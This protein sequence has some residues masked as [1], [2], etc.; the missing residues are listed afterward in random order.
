MSPWIIIKPL[1]FQPTELDLSRRRGWGEKKNT[2]TQDF[3]LDRPGITYYC[4]YLVRVSSQN[5]SPPGFVG[6]DT[7]ELGDAETR[8][9][10]KQ[11]I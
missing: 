10:E 7:G 4:N 2:R 9:G 11:T 3:T 6:G 5:G 1:P 8:S